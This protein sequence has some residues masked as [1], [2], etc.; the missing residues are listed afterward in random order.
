MQSVCGPICHMVGT[1]ICSSVDMTS[2]PT[3]SGGNDG[4]SFRNDKSNELVL[5]DV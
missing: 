1:K 3:S 2:H 5:Y 4:V